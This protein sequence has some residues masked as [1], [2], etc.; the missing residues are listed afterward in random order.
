MKKLFVILL[1]LSMIFSF[2][3]CGG[4]SETS[5]T[6][7]TSKAATTSNDDSD[8]EESEDN[9][10]SDESEASE[11]TNSEDESTDTSSDETLPEFTNKYVSYG[12]AIGVAVRGTDSTSIRFTK[13]NEAPAFGDVVLYTNDFGTT[14]ASGSETYED[15]A[16]LVCTYTAAKFSYTKTSLIAVGEDA[17]KATTKIPEDGFIVAIH[18]AQTACITS[19]GKTDGD[20]LFFVHGIQIGDVS[21]SLKKATATPKV[22]GKVSATEYG[23]AKWVVNEDNSLWDYSQ[24]EVGNYYETA[25]VYATYDNTNLYIGVV[26]NIPYHYCPLAQADAGTMWKYT[27]IQVNVSSEDPLGDYM[28]EHFDYAIDT[29]SVTDNVVRQYG[30][31]VNGD[32]ESL[33]CVWIGTPTT[34]T[35]TAKC[36]RNDSAQETVYEVAIPWSELGS[37]AHPFTLADAEKI[38]LSVSINSTSE[39]DATAGLWKNLKLRDGG[40]I[41]GRNDFSKIASVELK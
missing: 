38:G 18:K 7:D 8:M 26:V 17:T 22:D 5:S 15:F 37:T 25:E 4:D 35:G 14:I 11:A 40:G 3:A 33:S 36:V 32:G 19:V 39:E 41:I 9:S 6:S 27:C 1:A 21:I 20:D 31:S 16:I 10:T 34:F 2:S 23:A 13:I 30:F 24:F 12:G 28:S 29:Q